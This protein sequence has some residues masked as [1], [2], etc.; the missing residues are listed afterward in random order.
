MGYFL[1]LFAFVQLVRALFHCLVQQ[2][3]ARRE[4]PYTY[5]PAK[6]LLIQ[7]AIVVLVSIALSVHHIPYTW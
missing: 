1:V 7:V 6:S 4:L 2:N 5:E 3:K